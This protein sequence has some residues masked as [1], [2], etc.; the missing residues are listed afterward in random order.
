MLDWLTF[1]LAFVGYVLLA[2]DGARRWRGHRHPALLCAAAAVILAHVTCVWGLRFG[3]SLDAALA[4]GWPPFLLFHGALSL[5]VAA[6][7]VPEPW[8]TRLALTALA[9]VT[10]G[11]LP[12]PFRYD[13]LAL[14]RLPMLAVAA[15]AV[16]LAVRPRKPI[17]QDGVRARPAR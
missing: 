2:A 4:K 6:V 12:A 10:A 5:I 1:G 8:R 15:A 7:L 17:A 11:A 9:V 14:L 13:E 16:A 3:G